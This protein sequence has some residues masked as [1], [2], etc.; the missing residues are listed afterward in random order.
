[1]SLE[2]LRE[3]QKNGAP[4]E[5]LAQAAAELGI[6]GF[7]VET[8]EDKELAEKFALLREAEANGAPADLLEAAAAE[9]GLG[10]DYRAAL[11][12]DAARAQAEQAEAGRRLSGAEDSIF[13]NVFEGM[14]TL[15]S[16]INK[17]AV[18]AAD[19][20]T[21]PARI[22]GRNHPLGQLAGGLLTEAGL[23]PE[24]PVNSIADLFPEGYQPGRGDF[25]EEREIG[26]AVDTIGQGVGMG[27]SFVPVARAQG[28]ASAAA[29]AMGLGMTDEVAGAG[30][31]AAQI[32]AANRTELEELSR[33]SPEERMEGLS[34]ID[35]DNP[36]QVQYFA[37]KFN[38]EIAYE[39]T[40]DVIEDIMA[41]ENFADDFSVAFKALDDESKELSSRIETTT[42]R[43]QAQ[44]RRNLERNEE[45]R[46]ELL[47]SQKVQK[48]VDAIQKRIDKL[49]KTA[50]G[51]SSTLEQVEGARK[52]IAE[53]RKEQRKLAKAA[54]SK[55][56]YRTAEDIANKK[57]SKLEISYSPTVEAEKHLTNGL[58]TVE[59][60]AERFG[61]ST[62]DAH[63]ALVKSGGLKPADDFRE[64]FSR[65]SSSMKQLFR[66]GDGSAISVWD[67]IW[68]PATALM[69]D[70]VGRQAAR[71]YEQA[72]EGAAR[73][74]ELLYRNYVNN[75]GV[76]RALS[77]WMETDAIKRKFLNLHRTGNAGLRELRELSKTLDPKV[78]EM[79]EGLIKESQAHRAKT[80]K[81]YKKEAK[82][83]AVYW[84]SQ[85]K[86][87][88]KS[89]VDQLAEAFQTVRG[90]PTKIEG[91][92][93]RFRG[94]A[95]ELSAEELAKYENPMVAQL[96][97]M[98][99]EITAKHLTERFGLRATLGKNGDMNDLFDELER[100]AAASGGQD[101]ATLMRGL[102]QDTYSGQKSAPPSWMQQFMK[103]SYAG[104]LGQVDSAMMNLHDIAISAWRNGAKNTSKA[105]WDTLFTK[106]GID[107]RE[108]GITNT[109]SSVGEF[110]EGVGRALE[111]TGTVDKVIDL[112][113]DFAFK[114]SGFQMMD[115]MG[116]GTTM[117]AALHSFRDAAKKPGFVKDY[118]HLVQPR[119]AAQVKSVLANGTSITDMT[120]KQRDIVERMMF[121]KLGEQQLISAAGR[122]LLYLQ[123]PAARPMWAMTGFAVKQMDMLKMAVYDAAKRGDWKE[124]GEAAVGYMAYAA[125]GYAI[126]D[127]VRDMPSFILSGDEK[128]A[129]TAENFAKR[130][131]DQPLAAASLNRLDTQTFGRT[132]SDPVGE[133]F[134]SAAP[135]G[136]AIGNVAKD[137]GRAITGKEFRGYF[138]KSI[139]FG[140]FLYDA[141]ND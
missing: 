102:I 20:I 45:R 14:G 95:D 131:V 28:A 91:T 49:Q 97:R 11:E 98:N 34:Q 116:K 58:R 134:K 126:V 4:P 44:A 12:G 64:V 33:L 71:D 17:G 3:A 16:G 114:A 50:D 6:E 124:A 69:R 132:M 18:A 88:E 74:S 13:E 15:A 122:P 137:A 136:G 87:E 92:K 52:G 41:Q 107:L 1:M 53:L 21:A 24:G 139:P 2:L 32:N 47:E 108:M 75:P 113:Q 70:K 76:S 7:E 66:D 68:R 27:V 115:R 117:R 119:E 63:R 60:M 101:K 43:E 141:I 123:V 109:N 54:P 67:K 62:T 46:N 55:V 79:F 25:I 90:K 29:E 10:D 77:D 128:K 83:D 35:L 61:I 100:V 30:S 65:N 94:N 36:T 51:E 127:T 22:A 129:P 81:M 23:L 39:N 73:D 5:L 56:K 78:Q 86:A 38:D 37:N 89:T 111:K 48:K 8:D 59:R 106:D 40:S 125:V 103:Q 93:E 130:V 118:A 96:S 112:Y 85:R 135:P 31:R 121:A 105:L 84:A 9:L 138:L 42:G 110:R 82:G 140:D 72:F 120:A 57:A 26:Q 104:T 99:E 19:M 80:D 133:T